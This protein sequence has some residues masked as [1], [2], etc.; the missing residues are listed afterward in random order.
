MKLATFSHG[1]TVSY[2]V[3]DG[4]DIFDLGKRL[5]D[6]FPDLRSLIEQD[7][8]A[9]AASAVTGASSDL[10]TSDIQWLPVIPNPDKIVCIGLNYKSHI[11]ETG[12]SNPEDR[13][14]VFARFAAS[15]T[16]HMQP[17]VCPLE[18]ERYDFEGELVAVIGKRGRRIAESAALQHVAGYSIYNDASVRDFQLH[19]HQWGPGKNFPD[20]GAFGPWMVTGDEIPDPYALTLTTRL[21]GEVMQNSGTDLM[22]FDIGAIIAYVSTFTELVP[23]DVIVTGT[24]GGVGN[25]RKPPIYMH[26]G[27]VVEVEIT[28][29][30]TLRNMVVKEPA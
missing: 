2:G 24:P 30:G 1:G 20:S 10:K 4:D 23:G 29:I 15:Q 14:V 8:L 11:N 7:G 18:S 6:R 19:T 27:D 3:V 17:L 28:G 25:A 26:D 13:P 12:R 16:G 22:V 9:E 21:N 5:G